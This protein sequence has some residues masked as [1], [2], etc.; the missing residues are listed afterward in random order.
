MKPRFFATATELRAWLDDNHATA[1]ELW[2]GFYRRGTGK[3]SIT[4]AELVD[5]ELCFGWIDGVRRGIDDVSYSN[6]ITP[7]KPRSTWSAINI[8]RAKE[9]IK[10][11]RMRPA[12]LRAFERRT[13]ERSAIYSYEQRQAARLDPE[14]ERA[15]RFNKKAWAFFES[16]PPSYRRTAIYWVISAKREETR[17]KRLATLIRDSQN[18]RTIGPV[19]RAPRSRG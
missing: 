14:A 13:D 10:H 5:E 3:T 2:V 16:Q 12:G 4:W 6:R 18:G 19:S 1:T 17:Q 9:L 11:G 15:F 7:R 8:A